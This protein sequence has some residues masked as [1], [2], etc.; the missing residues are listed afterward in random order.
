MAGRIRHGYIEEFNFKQ[1]CIE[2]RNG[3][4]KIFHYEFHINKSFRFVGNTDPSDESIIYA[5]S[6]NKYYLKGIIVN[7][8]EQVQTH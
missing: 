3:T 4:F 7:G 2:C 1:N 8:Y 6:S 5:I